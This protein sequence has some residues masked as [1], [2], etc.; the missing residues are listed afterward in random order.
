MKIPWQVSGDELT[1]STDSYN[2][3]RTV[4]TVARSGLTAF[5]GE[6]GRAA[7]HASASVMTAP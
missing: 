6:H 7:V 3:K 2:S 5:K 4:Q 1:A